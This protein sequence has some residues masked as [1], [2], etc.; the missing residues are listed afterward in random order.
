M[1]GALF[2]VYILGAGFWV[3]AYLSAA[4]VALSQAVALDGEEVPHTYT[5]TA[6]DDLKDALA[7][8]IW[9]FILLGRL[10]DR[11]FNHMQVKEDQ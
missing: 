7:F 6:L 10:K 9:P 5:V 2:A 3:V 8:P 1:I 4:L 11:L